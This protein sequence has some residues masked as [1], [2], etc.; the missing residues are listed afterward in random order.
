MRKTYT[1]DIDDPKNIELKHQLMLKAATWGISL[2][3]ALRRY[4]D[5]IMGHERAKL[6]A[7]N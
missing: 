5:L 6:K 7:M 4:V 3:E 1:I 2:T